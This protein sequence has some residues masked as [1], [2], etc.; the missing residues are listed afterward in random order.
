MLYEVIGEN[1]YEFAS[2]FGVVF[3]VFKGRYFIEE[4]FR[5]EIVGHFLLK[6]VEFIV[7]K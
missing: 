6:K 7:A 5:D 2:E 4:D 3:F 1:F